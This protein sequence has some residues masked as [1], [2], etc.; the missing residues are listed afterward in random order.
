[1]ISHIPGVAK[2]HPLFG[3]DAQEQGGKRNGKRW[4]PPFGGPTGRI[5]SEILPDRIG[6]NMEN[7]L[8]TKLGHVQPQLLCFG[9]SSLFLLR[10]PP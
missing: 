7:F 3:A 10:H 8:R 5:S 1:M 4:V 2:V 9:H 6:S